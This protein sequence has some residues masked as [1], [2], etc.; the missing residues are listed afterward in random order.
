M[1]VL[2]C[3]GTL[4]LAA[5][6]ALDP[7]LTR[8]P[9]LASSVPTTLRLWATSPAHD[10]RAAQTALRDGKP[11][12]EAIAEAWRK[13]PYFSTVWL[14]AGMNADRAAPGAG[15]PFYAEALRLD[16]WGPS[17]ARVAV[18]AL[19]RARWIDVTTAL[20]RARRFNI[21]TIYAALPVTP[22]PEWPYDWA[23]TE[24]QP[25]E[26]LRRHQRF[27]WLQPLAAEDVFARET[28][29]VRRE[30][31]LAL[32]GQSDPACGEL[33]LACLDDR[34]PCANGA[35]VDADLLT[36]A[37]TSA[38]ADNDRA[39]LERLV[40]LAK[41]VARDRQLVTL[42][43]RALEALGQ[44]DEAAQIRRLHPALAAH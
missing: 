15:L 21:A 28:P 20:E 32:C 7:L 38:L 4:L 11:A 35:N 6:A 1:R 43:V 41:P 33:L 25:V 16:P 8:F 10:I 40:P 14:L 3:T 36:V 18:P 9:D 13:A 27:G 42:L 22:P 17:V 44:R 31:L 37:L 2:I 39:L 23:L 30:V 19:L 34:A 29:P 26:Q 5:L 12:D 24:R